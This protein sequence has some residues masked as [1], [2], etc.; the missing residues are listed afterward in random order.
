MVRPVV[1]ILISLTLCAYDVDQAEGLCVLNHEYWLYI[2]TYVNSE[3]AWGKQLQPLP[4]KLWS[5][6]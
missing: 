6:D 1:D 4:G 2:Y 3:I 5:N